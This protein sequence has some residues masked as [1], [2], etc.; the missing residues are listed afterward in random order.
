MLLYDGELA[1]DEVEA[2]R[3]RIGQDAEWREAIAGYGRLGDA[4]RTAWQSAAGHA[5]D[6]TDVV[7]D[8]IRRDA[9]TRLRRRGVM[10]GGGAAGVALGLAAA[11]AIWLARGPALPDPQDVLSVSPVA[12][13]RLPGSA[14]EAQEPA[15]VTE[16][17]VDLTPPVAIEAVD[18]GT[19][20]GSI[21]M[22]GSG[23]GATPVVWVMDG[24]SPDEG[25]M[26][27]L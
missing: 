24:P 17:D 26:P 21:F 2:L 9:R 3:E 12:L 16:G 10:L 4:V 8:R 7:M 15:Q 27:Q 19:R 25:R 14:P 11:V 20:N 1:A 22:V 5:P 6:L 18:F 13:L 23:V